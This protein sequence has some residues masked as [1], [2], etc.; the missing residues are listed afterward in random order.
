[1]SLGEVTFTGGTFPPGFLA[2]GTF[3]LGLR[4]C[5]FSTLLFTLFLPLMLI[6][7]PCSMLHGPFQN[8]KTGSHGAS[9]ASSSSLWMQRDL[10]GAQLDS[11]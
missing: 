5:G 4:M 8:P 9:Y 11:L 6:S 7:L 3:V 2:P 1:M 10:L